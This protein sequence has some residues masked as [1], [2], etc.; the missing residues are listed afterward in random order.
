MKYATHR[1]NEYFIVENRTKQGLDAYLPASGLAVYHC[2]TLG[3]NE[4]QGGTRDRHYQ[5]GLLQADGHLD[6]ETNRN[7]GDGTD[8]FKKVDG[9]VLSYATVPSTRTWDSSD[10][11]LAVSDISEPG[12]VI[13]LK[14]GAIVVPPNVVTG[15][16]TADL[17]IPDNKPE[18]ISSAIALSQ[19]GKVKSLKVGVDITHTYVGDLQVEVQAPSGKKVM[20]HDRL[21]RAQRNLQ[22]TYSFASTPALAALG[23]ESLQ[24]NWRLTVRDLASR[25]VGRLNRWNLEIE[26]ESTAQV[27]Q[28]EA[29]PNLS[30]PDNKPEGISSTIA[31][32]ESGTLKEIVVGV[33]I[34]HS[35]IGDLLVDIVAPS[36]QSV[37]LH[38]MLG[39]SQDDLRMTYDRASIPSLDA[40]VGQPIQGN[41]VLRVKDLQRSDTGKLEKWSLKLTL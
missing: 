17:L 16:V 30:I 24:G 39:G 11:G 22:Q 25:D 5:C 32:A 38:N 41:W 2:D 7:L 13:R 10:S 40:L 8:L 31:I 1:A 12:E 21:G 26:Y 9:T 15:E 34:V 35:Y 33:A 4:W 18:G 14:V 28:G 20:L 3:S 23:G 27:A 37:T 36:G 6:L 29:S 19:A